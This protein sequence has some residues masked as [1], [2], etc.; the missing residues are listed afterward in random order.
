V[1]TVCV[2]V[3]ACVSVG[4]SGSVG[5]GVIYLS[6]GIAVNGSVGVGFSVSVGA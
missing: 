6:V 5:F 4:D 1:F 3:C 2:S